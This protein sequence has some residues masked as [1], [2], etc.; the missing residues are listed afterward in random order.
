[1][2]ETEFGLSPSA[3]AQGKM[4]PP[5]KEA[6]TSGFYADAELY[7]QAE[8]GRPGPLRKL[9]TR[10]ERKVAPGGAGRMR[11]SSPR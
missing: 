7:F 5:R 10:C 8:L 4:V 1:M 2:R 3:L 6:R 9:N 11:G